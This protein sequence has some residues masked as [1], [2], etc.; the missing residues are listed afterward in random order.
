MS[1]LKEDPLHRTTNLGFLSFVASEGIDS[2]EV[3]LLKNRD[4]NITVLFI[5]VVEYRSLV[6]KEIVGNGDQEQC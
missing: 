6:P 2:L 4:K 5:G 1:T 3:P